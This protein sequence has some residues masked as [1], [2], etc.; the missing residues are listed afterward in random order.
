MVWS[1]TGSEPCGLWCEVDSSTTSSTPGMRRSE[2]EGMRSPA[3][4]E[5]G[6]RGSGGVLLLRDS[7]LLDFFYKS[8]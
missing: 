7:G 2:A 3:E 1:V 4:M 6:E 5:A 8:H